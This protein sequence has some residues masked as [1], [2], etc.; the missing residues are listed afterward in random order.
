MK[1]PFDCFD[2]IKRGFFSIIFAD[3]FEHQWL[4]KTVIYV[5]ELK[6]GYREYL[7]VKRDFFEENQH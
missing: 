5:S 1:S 7:G 4:E 6:A 2:R 3:S